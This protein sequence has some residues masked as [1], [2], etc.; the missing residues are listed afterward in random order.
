MPTRLTAIGRRL[1]P[2]DTWRGRLVRDIVRDLGPMVPSPHLINNYMYFVEPYQWHDRVESGT[3]GPL[4]SVVV[5]AFNTPDAYLQPLVDSLINQL[6][7]GFEVIFADASTDPGRAAAIAQ[8]AAL[9]DRFTYL[10]L[11][12]NEGI[13]ANTNAALAVARAPYVVFADHDDVLSL[14]ALNEVAHSLA[15]DPSIDI[16][17]SD[18]DAL[19]EDGLKRS[20]P[21]FKPVWSPHMFLTCNYTN[22]LSVI[23]RSLIEQAGGLRP[24]F[25]GAQDYDLLLRLH[26]APQPPKV[27]HIPAILYHWRQAAESTSS[28]VGAK[29]Y[30]ID[31]GRNAL[32]EYLARVGV[33]SA[34]VDDLPIQPSWHRIRPRWNARVAVVCTGVAAAYMQD[35]V[36]ATQVDRCRPLWLAQPDGF[37]PD[38]L[39]GD[40]DAVVVLYRHYLPIEPDWLDDLVGALTLPGVALVAPMLGGTLSADRLVDSVG[41]TRDALGVTPLLRGDATASGNSAGLA[42]ML[43]DV[44][45]VSRAVVAVRY[46]DLDLLQPPPPPF[47]TMV[48]VPPE[49]GYTVIWGHQCLLRQETFDVGGFLNPNL[50]L[51]VMRW[52]QE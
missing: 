35:L 31:A 24:Q 2:F 47:D 23:R 42:Q 4:F 25:D 10:R 30:A 21:A 3:D 6:Y 11:P 22:H 44:D 51:G 16:F 7:G 38:A 19:S 20:R 13:S 17:Y 9:D 28:T 14:H 36:D 1:F 46:R 32:A 27:C 26:T 50:G 18:E 48:A 33:D 40:V 37:D 41:F 15:D 5:P 8:A 34:G 52:F 29:T 39:P 12:R 43:R 49:R 45:A